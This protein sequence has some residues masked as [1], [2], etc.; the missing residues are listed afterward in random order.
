[1]AKLGERV[2]DE[3][4]RRLS[5]RNRGRLLSDEHR[6]A[7]GKGVQESFERRLARRHGIPASPEPAGGPS[8]GGA[9]PEGGGAS[10]TEERE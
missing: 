9:R 1:M 6:A 10:G 3:T 2:S 5:E 7:I 4:R 8:G